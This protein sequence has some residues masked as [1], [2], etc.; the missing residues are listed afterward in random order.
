MRIGLFSKFSF[1]VFSLVFLSSCSIYESNGREIIE[2]NQGGIVASGFSFKTNVYYVCSRSYVTPEF[3]KAPLEVI[4]TEYEK[5]NISVLY[6]EHS[7][8]HSVV[9]Y[10]HNVLGELYD[11]CKMFFLKRVSTE[12][13]ILDAAQLGIEQLKKFSNVDL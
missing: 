2:K 9:V 10:H 12:S 6:N 3:L 5:K 7:Q 13:Q 1:T 4:E 11:S 8:P